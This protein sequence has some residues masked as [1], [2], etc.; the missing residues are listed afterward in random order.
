MIGA[1]I[2]AVRGLVGVAMATLLLLSVE[3]AVA[4]PLPGP[5]LH[6]ATGT[7]TGL[8]LSDVTVAGTTCSYSGRRLSETVQGFAIG[9]NVRIACVGD[10]LRTIALVP[11]TSGPSHPDSIVV[12]LPDSSHS[13]GGAP[14][15]IVSSSVSTSGTIN[16]VDAAARTSPITSTVLEVTVDGETCSLPIYGGAPGA[17][18]LQFIQAGAWASMS[19]TIYTN[20]LERGQLTV[21]SPGGGSSV[22]W[23]FIT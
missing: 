9:E 20:G 22:N 3:P 6:T 18:G 8:D 15:L 17:K 16:D 12:T 21:N 11:I 23:N 1:G 14:S 2:I 5:V 4:T 10:V 13:A 19:G 7:I